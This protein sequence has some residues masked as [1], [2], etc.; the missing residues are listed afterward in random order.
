MSTE[1]TEK[2]EKIAKTENQLLDEAE[3]A[4]NLIEAQ[5]FLKNSRDQKNAKSLVILVNGIELGGKGES[6]MQLRE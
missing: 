4:L 6:V 2:T 1:K 3:L 5:Y